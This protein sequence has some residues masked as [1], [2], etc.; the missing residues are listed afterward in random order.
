MMLLGRDDK[1]ESNCSDMN[2]DLLCYFAINLFSLD[3]ALVNFM[4]QVS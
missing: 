4:G 3:I 2:I 1:D